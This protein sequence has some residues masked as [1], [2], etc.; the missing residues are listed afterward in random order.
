LAFAQAS[1]RIPVTI[2]ETFI[3]GLSVLIVKLRFDISEAT[4]AWANRCPMTVS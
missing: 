2:H 4:M 3:L 1:W